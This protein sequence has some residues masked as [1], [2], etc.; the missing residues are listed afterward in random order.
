MSFSIILNS[1][2]TRA[3]VVFPSK[4]QLKHVWDIT[5]NKT[6]GLS[7]HWGIRPLSRTQVSGVTKFVTVDQGFEIIL[8]QDFVTTSR[9]DASVID[10]IAELHQDI[11]TFYS[12]LQETKAGNTDIIN[13]SDLTVEEA[14]VDNNSSNV[15]VRGQFTIRYR[16]N[17]S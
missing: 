5:A 9:G 3:A 12:D 14:E 8:S 6:L 17:F 2:E 15:I 1:L 16:Y 13:V 10:K 7:N 4:S 11:D